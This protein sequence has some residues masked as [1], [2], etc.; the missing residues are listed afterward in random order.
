MIA[1]IACHS[2]IVIS[3]LFVAF[4]RSSLQSSKRL[5][6]TESPLPVACNFSVVFWQGIF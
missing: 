2:L 5:M 1:G 4:S 3:R 6:N